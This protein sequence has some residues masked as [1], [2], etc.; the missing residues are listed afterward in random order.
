MNEIEKTP[1]VFKMQRVA[2]I[3]D[4]VSLL[5]PYDIQ[6]EAEKQSQQVNDYLKA[7]EAQQT[8]EEQGVNP[9]SAGLASRAVESEANSLDEARRAVSDS[10]TD[11]ADVSRALMKDFGNA[12]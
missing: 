3:S 6:A 12:N 9:V 10:Q 7:R 11:D 4:G 8:A 5:L 1:E 2:E